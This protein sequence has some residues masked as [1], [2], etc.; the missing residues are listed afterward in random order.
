MRTQK[1]Y[2]LGD[3][4]TVKLVAVRMF[5]RELDFSLVA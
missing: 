2:A 3:P 4:I 1:Q 5:E